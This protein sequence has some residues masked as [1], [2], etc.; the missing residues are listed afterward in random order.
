ME[1][2]AT[3]TKIVS[4]RVY[5]GSQSASASTLLVFISSVSNNQRGG[6][7]HS[8]GNGRFTL[9]HKFINLTQIVQMGRIRYFFQTNVFLLVITIKQETQKVQYSKWKWRQLL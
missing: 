7:G 8:S 4:R 1:C 3:E 9:N 5:R 2:Q 6:G